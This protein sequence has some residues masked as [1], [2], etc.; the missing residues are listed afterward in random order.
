LARRLGQ[1]R[2]DPYCALDDRRSQKTAPVSGRGHPD[3]R[4]AIWDHNGW[5]HPVTARAS[6]SGMGMVGAGRHDSWLD[7]SRRPHPAGCCSRLGQA[8]WLWSAATW[9][10]PNLAEG[11]LGVDL[12]LKAS[13]RRDSVFNLSVTS[14]ATARSHAFGNKH[15]SS[16]LKAHS[17]TGR[18]RSSGFG[19]RLWLERRGLSLPV[20]FW[21]TR[22]A[23]TICLCQFR[24]KVAASFIVSACLCLGPCGKPW[25]YWWGE[26]QGANERPFSQIPSSISTS[27]GSAADLLRTTHRLAG[28]AIHAARPGHHRCRR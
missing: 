6:C 17:A 15:S 12:E 14:I 24:R 7:R 25:R 22:G 2:Y 16:C 20:Q 21:S 26:T 18:P 9:T 23:T 19:R 3:G 28:P 10:A 4:A 1:L 8:F 11:W 13:L 27:G 5:A